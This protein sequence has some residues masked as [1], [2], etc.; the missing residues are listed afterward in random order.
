MKFKVGDII[1][2]E[3]KYSNSPLVN[4]PIIITDIVGT[5]YHTNEHEEDGHLTTFFF[6]EDSHWCDSATRLAHYNTK[7]GRILYGKRH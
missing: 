1:L 6:Q 2:V 3:D 5:A 7:L 4:R